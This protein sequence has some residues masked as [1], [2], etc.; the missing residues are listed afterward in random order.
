MFR[1]NKTAIRKSYGSLAEFSRVE[2]VSMS[3][4][5]SVDKKKSDIFKKGSKT[6]EAFKALVAKG[7]IEEVQS[8]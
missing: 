2:G 5:K 6:F 7:Y 8:V 4:I 1:L 3:L